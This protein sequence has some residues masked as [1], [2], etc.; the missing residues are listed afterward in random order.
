[1]RDGRRELMLYIAGRLA[2]CVRQDGDGYLTFSYAAGY[3]GAPV[4][5]SMPVSPVTYPQRVVRP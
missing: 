5:L 1:M 4:S 3:S 2:G